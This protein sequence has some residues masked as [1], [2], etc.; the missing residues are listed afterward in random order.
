MPIQPWKLLR[1]KFVLDNPWYKVRKDAVRLPDGREVDDYFVSVR[2]EVVLTFPVT[3][4]GHAVLVRQYK[5]G[6]QQVVLEFPGGVFD[7]ETEAAEAAAAREMVEETGYT[8]REM[9]FLGTLWDDATKQNNR[10]HLFLGR[11]AAATADQ[12]LDEI[13]DIEVVEVPV[14]ALLSMIQQGEFS[15]SGS[16]SLAYMG[17]QA[18]GKRP[19]ES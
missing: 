13:E 6:A 18:L 10:L 14:D 16:V 7:A 15:V 2:P 1:S 11:G 3:D 12:N 4:A 5:H 19:L 8:A 17:L 9:Q